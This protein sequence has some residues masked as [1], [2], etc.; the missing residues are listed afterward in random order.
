MTK[1][2]SDKVLAKISKGASS[3]RHAEISPLI[4]GQGHTSHE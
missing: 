2:K 3:R 1:S 4:K